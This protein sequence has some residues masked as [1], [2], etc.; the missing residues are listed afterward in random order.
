LVILVCFTENS[1]S[2][3]LGVDFGTESYK[4]A[5]VK[6][7]KVDIV[8]NE[9][10]RRKTP[11]L[12]A[13]YREERLFNDAGYKRLT[14]SPEKSFIFLNELL[15]RTYPVNPHPQILYP[16]SED[17]ERHSLAF[18]VD[19]LVFSPEELVAMIL[20]RLKDQTAVY[21]KG[22]VKDVVITVPP[23]WTHS[24]RQALIDA[25][26]VAGLNILSL[27]NE[28]TAVAMNYA[29]MRDVT[30][31]TKNVIF[32]DMGETSTKVSVVSFKIVNVKDKKTKKTT[33]MPSLQVLG[34][35]W[36]DSLGGRDFD[37]VLASEL[38]ERASK[39]LKTDIK[40]DPRAM[41]LLFKEAK[42]VKE[43][44]SANTE[45]YAQVE[46]LTENF[47]LKELVTR[48]EFEELS[49]GFYSRILP[50]IQAALD[51]ANLKKAY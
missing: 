37:T 6:A 8:E 39:K 19:D 36:D 17:P 34:Y 23:F 21:S 1:L 38:A 24:Q 5:L 49:K 43:V 11:N 15:G 16:I 40:K 30:N 35:G 46:G 10:S 7:G 27:L 9:D 44:L 4:V 28:D 3:V 14:K 33:K 29:L 2:A 18:T 45:T 48:T 50:P 42:R 22:L 41:A 25:G 31:V 32:Y 51:F 13:F 26:R 20:E 12:I 47:N